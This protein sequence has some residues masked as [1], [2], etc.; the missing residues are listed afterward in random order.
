[1]SIY[2]ELIER[3]S[4]GEPFH[5]DFEKRNMKVGKEYLIKDGAFDESRELISVSASCDLQPVFYMI[6][7]LYKRYK[8]SLPSERSDNKRRKYFKALPM[9]EL[10]DKQ[11]MIAERREIT[12]AALEGFVLCM[13]VNGQLVWNE[14][15]ME[16]KWFWQ[17][18]TDPDLVLLRSWVE[19][20]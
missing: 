7:I 12:Q 1:M 11:L 10:T 3:V 8:Y 9:E 19:C 16:G 20:K 2:L 18:K 4:N 5:I 14:D 15:V 17:S 6:E 13:I